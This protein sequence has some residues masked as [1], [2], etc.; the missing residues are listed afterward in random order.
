MKGFIVDSGYRVMHGMPYVCLYG[1]SEEGEAFLSL[2]AYEPYFFIREKDMDEASRVEDFRFEE[3][4]LKNFSDEKMVKVLVDI[5]A[6]VAKLRKIFEGEGIKTYEADILF[7]R[8]FLIDKNIQGG[9]EISGEYEYQNDVKVYKNPEI[10]SALVSVPLKTLAID[11]ETD[12]QA[13]SIYCI[14]LVCG[15]YKK[16]LIVSE[17][18]WKSAESFSTEKDMLERFFSLV[19][20]LDPDI[21]MGWHVIEFDLHVI[22]KR[23]QKLEVAFVLGRIAEVSKIMIK[24]G[25]F[26]R[27]RVI[28]EG[29][30]VVDLLSWVKDAVKLDDY[31]LETAAQYYLQEKKHVQF[32]SKGEEIEEMYAKQTQKLIDYNMKDSV[33]VLGILVKSD[34]LSLYMRRSF[35]TGLM[36]DDVRGSIASLDSIYLKKLRSRGYVA[37]SVAH[38]AKDESITG[39]YVM[40]SK[41]GMYENI[42]VF[43]FKSLYPSLMRTFNIDPLSFGK[44]GIKAPNGA[45]F[46][47]KPGVMPEI[48]EELMKVREEYKQKKDEVGRYA[49]KILMNSFFGVMASPLCRFYSLD[50]AN[51]ITSFAQFFIKKTAA[52]IREE[53]YEV[54]YSDTDSVFVIGGKKDAQKLGEELQHKINIM[55]KD[56]IHAEYF[57]DSHLELEFEKVYTKFIMPK[58]RGVDKGAKKRYA[59]IVKGKLEVVGMEAVRGDWTPVAKKFQEELLKRVFAGQRVQDFIPHFVQELKDGK[60]DSLLVYKK[61]LRKPLKDYLKTTPPHVKA[62]RKLPRFKGKVV[63]YVYTT[64]GA[65]P[66]ELVKGKIDYEHYVQKQLKPIADSVL[67]FLNLKFDELLSGQRSLFGYSSP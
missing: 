16:V 1:R 60:Y 31:K 12:M 3:S 35:L 48:I 56:Y 20:E 64:E 50:M 65:E 32:V 6:D 14:S 25:Y 37:P 23:C 55:L 49:I 40:D 7:P 11:I 46:A 66:I 9:V 17:K 58:L 47:K 59:G 38:S 67:V 57:V 26:E 45:S 34:L 39:G 4:A 29:R 52:W 19:Q 42:L 54:I 28:A 2:H 51:A 5:P 41:P 33:L 44:K 62:A 27:S 24:E 8:R 22:K 43:D 10:H 15:E 63:R 30:Q 21:I 13:K 53:G 36:L 18:K 61:A